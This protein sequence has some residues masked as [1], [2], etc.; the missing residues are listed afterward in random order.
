MLKH[1]D[2]AVDT[3]TAGGTTNHGTITKLKR[4]K[5][6]PAV[7]DEMFPKVNLGMRP[8]GTRVTVQ[9]KIT[10]KMTKGGIIVTDPDI[11]AD[12][13]AVPWGKVV[14]IGRKAVT[15][16]D[17]EFKMGDIV[18][19]PKWGGDRVTIDEVDFTT[20]NWW[21]VIGVVEDVS[22]LP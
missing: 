9:L 4:R 17:G 15:E 13:K 3:F 14:G 10:P 8:S 22:I 18:R 6:T 21:D 11:D 19:I 5:I 7:L 12:R 2:V 20:F 1:E 16:C